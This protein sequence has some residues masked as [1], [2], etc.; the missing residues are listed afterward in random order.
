MNNF[1]LKKYL[2]NDLLPLAEQQYWAYWE[3]NYNTWQR[4]ALAQNAQLD[5]SIQII[6][7]KDASLDVVVAL[8]GNAN[9]T[10]PVQ[11]RLADHQNPVVRGDL[12][13]NRRCLTNAAACAL[14]DIDDIQRA[15]VFTRLAGNPRIP[16]VVQLI[17]A[18]HCPPA[19]YSLALNP[20]VTRATQLLLLEKYPERDGFDQTVYEILL[21]NSALGFE[22]YIDEKIKA[23]IEAHT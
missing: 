14:A 6:L 20:N 18:S 9:L 11:L 15:Y 19:R 5:E 13:Q 16:E 17:I 23:F 3:P 1:D 21:S 8:A 7:S 10:E 2:K 22:S 4:E 12:A